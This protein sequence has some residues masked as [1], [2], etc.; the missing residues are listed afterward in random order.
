MS[1][2]PPLVS[3][4]IACYNYARYLGEAVESVLGQSYPHFEC[5][6]VN[7][8]SQDKT[9]QVARRYLERDSRVRYLYQENRGAAAARN[10]GIAAAAGPQ[11]PD[12]QSGLSPFGN[13]GGTVGL[14]SITG[15]NLCISIFF[16]ACPHP[17]HE[18]PPTEYFQADAPPPPHVW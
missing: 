13:F 12:G 15:C 14:L 1:S 18:F 6:I 8:G 2:A 16:V 3:V 10:R 5:I 4:V 9:A 11:L 7:D 17:A